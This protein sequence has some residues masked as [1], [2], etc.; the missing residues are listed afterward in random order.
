MSIEFMIKQYNEAMRTKNYFSASIIY[1]R[2]TEMGY[3]FS[4]KGADNEIK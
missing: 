4:T 3:K 2:L 1:T